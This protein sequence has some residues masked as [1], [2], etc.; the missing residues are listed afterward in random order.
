MNRL[1][2]DQRVTMQK[3]EEER[4]AFLNHLAMVEFVVD[5]IVVEF[6]LGSAHSAEATV[7]LRERFIDQMTLGAQAR[8][9]A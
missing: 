1:S 2:P 5:D 3:F 8:C 6:I 4:G 9:V 7:L